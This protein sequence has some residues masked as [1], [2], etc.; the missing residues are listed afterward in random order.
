MNDY[1]DIINLP[2]H[3]SN[4]R[5]HMSLHDRA[6][7]FAPFA[8]PTG[9]DD[10]V[11]EARRLTDGKPE[12]DENQ[13]TELDQ[14]LTEL[15]KRISEHPEII[16]TYFEPDNKKDGGAYITF[17]GRLKKIDNYKRIFVFEDGR[18]IQICNIINMDVLD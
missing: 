16:I 17:I 10:A 6:A 15:T 5:P 1:E 7:Q 2:H 4:T 18:E 13:L 14:M 12:L 9:Y 8:A 11:K 3:Q